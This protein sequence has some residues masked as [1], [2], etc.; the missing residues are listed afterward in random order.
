ME[1]GC[2]R[3]LLNE[4]LSITAQESDAFPSIRT[5]GIFLNEVLSITA[6]E[7]HIPG[8]VAQFEPVLNE[9]LSITAQEYEQLHVL[10]GPRISSMK[11]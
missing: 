5:A 9:V 2:C 3:V 11:S 4:V 8:Y 10:E 6:Q 1:F 7:S